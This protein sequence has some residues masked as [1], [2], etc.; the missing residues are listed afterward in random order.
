VIK[1]H[2]IFA[3][4]TRPRGFTL[5]EASLT[6]VIIGV[7]FLA[8]LQLLAAGTMT[9]IRAIESTTAVNLAK[10]VREM[11]LKKKFSEISALDGA[12]YQPPIDSQGEAL[13]DFANW[14]Q[15]VAVHAVDPDRMTLDISNATPSAVRVSVQIEH[16][17][18]RVCD[19]SWYAFDP[20]P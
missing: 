3:R 9:N 13:S 16:N 2:N 20:N 19:V 15:T 10:N 5:I 4:Q 14:K 6:T 17:G 18:E 1:A 8:M 7:G 12:S 11:S